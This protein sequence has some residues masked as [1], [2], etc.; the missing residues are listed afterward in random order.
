M[1]TA[2]NAKSIWPAIAAMSAALPTVSAAVAAGTAVGSVQRPAT[3][4][5]YDLPAEAA[6]AA[7]AVTSNQ[8]WP[9]SNATNLWPTMP[10]APRTP[11]LSF[12]DIALSTVTNPARSSTSRCARRPLGGGA[13]APSAAVRA[14]AI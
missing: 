8:G 9:S 13:L 4:S 1:S 12:L 11:T 6:L 7:T 2:Q 5:A 14:A 10:V 3:A